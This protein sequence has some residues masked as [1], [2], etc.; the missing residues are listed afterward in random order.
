[1]QFGRGKVA[2]G[3]HDIGY[4]VSQARFGRNGLAMAAEA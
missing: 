1:M 4:G 3:G 2:V